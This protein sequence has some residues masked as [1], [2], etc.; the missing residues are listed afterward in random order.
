ML[1]HT[2]RECGERIPFRERERQR[3]S[4]SV[5]NDEHLKDDGGGKGDGLD[6]TFIEEMKTF[7]SIDDV[8]VCGAYKH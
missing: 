2:Q 7:V 1:Q 4:P 5:L 3:I 6:G 8:A